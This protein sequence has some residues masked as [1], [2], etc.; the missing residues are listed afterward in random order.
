MI[1]IEVNGVVVE[2]DLVVRSR[3]GALYYEVSLTLGA[4]K[5]NKSEPG[6]CR[7][8]AVDPNTVKM[9]ATEATLDAACKSLVEQLEKLELVSRKDTGLEVD[10]FIDEWTPRRVQ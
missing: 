2:A 3:D 6:K 5:G 4:L 9:G 8:V 1:G 7:P 10:G